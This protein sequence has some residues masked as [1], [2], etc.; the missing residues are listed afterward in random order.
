V[1]ESGRRLLV[2]VPL[3]IGAASHGVLA[4]GQETI[5]SPVADLTAEADGLLCLVTE[6]DLI[7]SACQRDLASAAGHL[8]ASSPEIAGN[9]SSSDFQSL[10][11]VPKSIVMVLV[12]FLCISL[13]RDARIWLAMA[14]FVLS[15]GNCWPT[16]KAMLPSCQRGKRHFEEV[17]SSRVLPGL[18][19]HVPLCVCLRPVLRE[20]PGRENRSERPEAGILIPPPVRRPLALCLTSG[21]NPAGFISSSFVFAQLPRGPPCG[22]WRTF[23]QLPW[24]RVDARKALAWQAD[25]VTFSL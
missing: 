3:L 16:A 18:R 22:P 5:C 13:V 4:A 14:A 17:A 6:G 24:G 7:T 9:S 8:L 12:G 1:L 11:A 19:E 2:L 21:A 23:C 15:L 25:R 10:P 20:N